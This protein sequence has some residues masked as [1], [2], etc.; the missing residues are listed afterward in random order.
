MIFDI[1]LNKCYKHTIK[2]VHI[3]KKA[4]AIDIDQQTKKISFD[5]R[6][7]F[8]FDEVV[9]VEARIYGYLQTFYEDGATIL[10]SSNLINSNEPLQYDKLTEEQKKEI[11]K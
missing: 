6:A 4:H 11:Y 5:N 7:L 1:Y 8:T 3:Q 2:L 10:H 9:A